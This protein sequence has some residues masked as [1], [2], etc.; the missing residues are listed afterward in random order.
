MDN[1]QNLLRL[2]IIQ[3]MNNKIA[4]GFSTIE[5]L[6]NLPVYMSKM[7]VELTTAAQ[8]I[9]NKEDFLLNLAL[10]LGTS[11]LKTFSESGIKNLPI[12]QKDFY[13][14]I[15]KYAKP[16]S[17]YVKDNP[18]RLI[19]V[20]LMFS[21]AAQICRCQNG[22]AQIPTAFA[23][24]EG[25]QIIAKVVENSNNNN[26][27]PPLLNCIVPGSLMPKSFGLDDEANQILNLL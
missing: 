4:R 5:F 10:Q 14:P 9:M 3:S 15:I 7:P 26:Q 21:S 2:L 13:L 12:E 16:L 8:H 20:V 22:W 23:L 27:F 18:D 25:C 19:S 1:I 24:E 17:L 11:N 6:T